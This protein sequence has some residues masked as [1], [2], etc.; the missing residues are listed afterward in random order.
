MP[1]L[2]TLYP[3]LD[4]LETKTLRNQCGF[5]KKAWWMHFIIS[6]ENSGSK[7][8]PPPTPKNASTINIE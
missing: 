7:Y 6:I 8:L 5:S 3:L 1:P 2:I 4:N